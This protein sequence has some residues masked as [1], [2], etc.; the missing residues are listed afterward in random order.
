MEGKNRKQ[1]GDAADHAHFA[2]PEDGGAFEEGF[3]GNEAGGGAGD[4]KGAEENALNEAGAVD[5]DAG[6]AGHGDDGRDDHDGADK[7]P[8]GEGF[9]EEEYGEDDDEGAVEAV[10]DGE[11]GGADGVKAHEE[12]GIGDADAEHAGAENEQVVTGGDGAKEGVAGEPHGGEQE[13]DGEEAFEEVEADGVYGFAAF[14]EEDDGEGPTDGGHEGQNRSEVVGQG[15]GHGSGRYEVWAGRTRGKQRGVRISSLA[16]VGGAKMGRSVGGISAGCFLI[17][18]YT[19]P[20]DRLCEIIN[21]LAKR[22]LSVL[23]PRR[24]IGRPPRNMPKAGSDVWQALNSRGNIPEPHPLTEEYYRDL[25]RRHIVRLLLTYILPIVL[26]TVYFLYQYRGL[27]TQGQQL[28]LLAAAEN[29]AYTLDLFLSE[30]RVNL[31]N[32]IDDPRFEAPPSSSAMD[33]Y[34]GKLQMNSETFVDLGFFDLTGVQTAYAGP[35][36][37]LEKRNYAEEEWWKQL[38]EPDHHFVITDIYLGFRQRPHFTIAVSRVID[39][40]YVVLRATLDP[41]KIHEYITSRQEIGEAYTSIVNRAGYYQVVTPDIGMP[42]EDSFFDPPSEPRFG[43]AEMPTRDGKAPC[44]YAWLTAADWAVVVHPVALGSFG[45]SGDFLLKF[46]GISALVSVLILGIIFNRA[47]G[48]VEMQRESDRTREQL[49]HAAKLASVGELAAGIAHEI[50]NPLAVINEQAGLMKDLMDP[51]F[52]TPTPPEQLTGYLDTIQAAVF[53]CRDITRKLLGF[54]RKTEMDLRLHDIHTLLDDVVVG[55]LGHEMT[56]SNVEVVKDYGEHIPQIVTDGNQLE[57]VVLNIIK[58]GI[59]ALEEQPGQIIIATWCE[60]GEVHIAI[61]DSGKGMTEDQL[62]HIFLPFYTTK[63]VGKGTGLGLS[64][65]YGIIKN[66]GGRLAVESQPGHGSTFT[67][68][69]PLRSQSGK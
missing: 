67:I 52:G 40:Q 36:S 68:T 31:D 9:G 28:H 20:V 42:L 10:D 18:G 5:V 46:I 45:L 21:F 30:R 17:N 53:R 57:Q 2:H 41:R 29:Q 34:L 54:V 15:V 69:L 64:V 50:N 65:S 38:R 8:D 1:D 55:L 56:V 3:D 24:P 13:D 22:S 33:G 35:F 44:A 14:F 39:S 12:E 19:I 27:V 16:E 23:R 7:L 48:L 47:Q 66:L 58:N 60:E 11:A 43:L 62:N 4:G 26:L 32:L 37:S 51:Q 6:F 59:D 63:E 25:K 49:G 61:R